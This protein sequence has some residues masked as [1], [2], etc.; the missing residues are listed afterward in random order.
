M[1]NRQA[2]F[3]EI[4]GA[5][6]LP[7]QNGNSDALYKQY[8][9]ITN[10]QPRI[11]FA[12]SLSHNTVVRG[13]YT[14]SNFLEGTGTNLRLTL[15]PPFGSEHNVNYTPTQTPSTLAQGY[16]I[17]GADDPNNINYTGTSIR[18]WSPNFRP[19]VSNQWNFSVQHQFGHS[20]TVQVAY[21][22][23]NNDL[24]G[25]DLGVA[26]AIAARW[27]VRALDGLRGPELAGV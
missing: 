19:A 1:H 17:F 5:L 26:A 10:F 15:N 23:Q 8:N 4:T 11:S 2:N 6:E 25:S 22:G 13:A 9:G 3:N 21:V 12:Y 7:G 16:T 14:L 18:L 20:L 24:S 27:H